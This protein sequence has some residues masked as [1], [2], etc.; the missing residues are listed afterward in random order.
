MELVFALVMFAFVFGVTIALT[1]ETAYWW[2][3][4]TAVSGLGFVAFSA[5]MLHH[6][7]GFEGL[8]EFVAGFV[9]GG[10]AMLIG[11]LGLA[12]AGLLHARVTRAP[13]AARPR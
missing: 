12:I 4:G 7:S 10:L 11:S 1:Y 8:G 6:S 9:L 13:A 3:P 2:A 5:V